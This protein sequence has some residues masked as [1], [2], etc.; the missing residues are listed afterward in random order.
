MVFT[1]GPQKKYIFFKLMKTLYLIIAALQI[2]MEREKNGLLSPHF[3]FQSVETLPLSSRGLDF[4]FFQM[5]RY[6]I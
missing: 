2:T 6:C 1:V 5:C 4:F 3:D